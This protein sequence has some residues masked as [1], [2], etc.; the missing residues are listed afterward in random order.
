[1]THSLVVGA[2]GGLKVCGGVAGHVGQA[3]WTFSAGLATGMASR[4]PRQMN[5][6]W[7]WSNRTRRPE[8]AAPV[9]PEVR[10]SGP[11]TGGPPE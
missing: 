7:P 2:D 5:G 10:D 3:T 6:D 11:T 1:M 9:L 4:S 8:R